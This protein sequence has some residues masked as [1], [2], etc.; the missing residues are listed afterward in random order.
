MIELKLENHVIFLKDIPNDL[1][2]ALVAKSNIFVMPSIIHKNSVEGFGIAFIEAAKCMASAS[3]AGGGLSMGAHNLQ[4]TT[5]KDHRSVLPAYLAIVFF[6]SASS[7][8]SPISTSSNQ[9]IKSSQIFSSIS[10]PYIKPFS[11]SFFTSIYTL[12]SGL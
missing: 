7:T 10:K 6:G 11:Y 4:N 2:N 5:G 12:I 8:C 3:V 1:K 9:L